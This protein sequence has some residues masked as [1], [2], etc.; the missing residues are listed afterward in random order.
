M[1]VHSISFTHRC[2]TTCTTGPRLQLPP[3]S[4]KESF[5]ESFCLS[6]HKAALHSPLKLQLLAAWNW[7]L[8]FHNRFC[9]NSIC[10]QSAIYTPNVNKLQFIGKMRPGGRK[11]VKTHYFGSGGGAKCRNCF[12]G[13]LFPIEELIKT[14]GT[15]R[16]IIW[17]STWQ[18][19]QSQGKKL[20]VNLVIIVVYLCDKMFGFELAP[21]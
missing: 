14:D 13:G 3:K 20:S 11:K 17:E 8:G 4:R 5:F 15:L 9:G 19:T 21:D 10:C 6:S 7:Q 18:I 2:T 12:Y 16:L 1:S